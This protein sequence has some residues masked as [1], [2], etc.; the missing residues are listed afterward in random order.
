MSVRFSI[1]ET[2][3]CRHQ[4]FRRMWT[5]AAG[6]PRPL[7][8]GRI[9]EPGQDGPAG[10]VRRKPPGIPFVRLYPRHSFS[11]RRS[12]PSP[13]H[14]LSLSVSVSGGGRSMSMSSA[15]TGRE[16]PSGCPTSFSSWRNRPCPS[17]ACPMTFRTFHRPRFPPWADVSADSLR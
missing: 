12:C 10:S 16:C 1:F 17:R 9:P 3:A 6:L 5:G 2:S 7:M 15:E 14:T 8:E 11:D 13:D 4:V